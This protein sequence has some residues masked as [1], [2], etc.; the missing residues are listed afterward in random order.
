MKSLAVPEFTW[1]DELN[2]RKGGSPKSSKRTNMFDNEPGI[3]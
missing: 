1:M 2:S 3:D